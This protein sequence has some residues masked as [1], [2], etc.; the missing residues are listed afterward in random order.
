MNL[1]ALLALLWLHEKVKEEKRKGT[2]PPAARP[3]TSK[4][5]VPRCGPTE[6]LTYIASEDRYVCLPEG[7]N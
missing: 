6:K 1:G 4:A 5:E 3:P 7:F 2:P